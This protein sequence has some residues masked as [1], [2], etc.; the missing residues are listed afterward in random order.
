MGVEG[1]L[2]KVLYYT[3]TEG[4]QKVPILPSSKYLDVGR[5]PKIL[6]TL[7]LRP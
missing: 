2:Q 4:V 1:V 7:R 3:Q 5:G 6:D